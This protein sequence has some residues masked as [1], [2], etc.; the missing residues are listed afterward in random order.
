M[1]I[2]AVLMVGSSLGMSALPVVAQT[3]AAPA[4]STWTAIAAMPMPQVE[5]GAALLDGKV[6]VIGGWANEAAPFGDV[7]IYDIAANA[8][9]AGVLLP[10]PVHH[11]GAVTVAGKIYAIGGFGKRFSEREP[12]DTIYI[13][14][15][16]TQKWTNGAPM[17]AP[18][19]AGVAAAI[20]TT[21]YYA[22]GE[23]RRAPGGPPPKPGSHAVYEPIADLL[24]YDTLKNTWTVLAPMK[25]ARDHAVGGA[26]DG[27]LYVV[28]GRDRPIYDLTDIEAFDP[29]TG[30]WTTRA[31]MPNGRSGGAGAALGGK[32]FVFGG[33]GNNA[34][35]SGIFPQAE[36]F[37]PATNAWT[38]F[39][40]MPVPRH[41]QVAIAADGRIL[42]PGGALKRGGSDVTGAGDAFE[43]K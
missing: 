2:F 13:F 1:K 4:P 27:K 9:S 7:Q 34:V 6:Y 10:Q 16:Q 12:L 37:D 25:V 35:A 17:P 43:P 33:E 32:F 30:V 31:P 14:D 38:R 24:A 18:R 42:I 20:G 26:L 8:W 28:G 41:S 19:G 36:A 22:G 15:P 3:N 40:D 23:R 5:A 11:H 39:A 21:I 29:A